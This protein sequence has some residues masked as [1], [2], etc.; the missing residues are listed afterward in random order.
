VVCDRAEGHACAAPPRRWSASA[1]LRT[2]TGAQLEVEAWLWNVVEGEVAGP[3]IFK[4][5]LTT[6]SGDASAFDLA[7]AAAVE[8][9]VGARTAEG[10]TW[11]ATSDDSHH[12]VGFL[13]IDHT[14]PSGGQLVGC[15]SGALHL[16][17]RDVGIPLRRFSWGD[18][19]L[20]PL[21]RD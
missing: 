7:A 21:R 15:Q 8:N 12:R 11:A 5:A 19:Y 13:Q 20:E 4:V 16:E 9:D 17:L 2:T 3:L 14:L 10:F 1:L 18:P 6:H